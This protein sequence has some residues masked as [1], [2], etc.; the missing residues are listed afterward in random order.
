MEPATIVVVSGPPGAGKT[1]L[2]ARL[3]ERHGWTVLAK[4]T[5]KEALF[6]TLGTRDRDWSRR[7]SDASFEMVFRLA[8]QAI[9]CE[10]VI[11]LEGNFR[12]A[13]HFSRVMRL[14]ATRGAS[15]L[16]V[17]LAAS[18][19]VLEQRL[20]ERAAAASRHAGHRDAELVDELRQS[21][22]L[23]SEAP[24]RGT[25]NAFPPETGRLEFDTRLLDDAMLDRI[26][27]EV[28]AA[29]GEAGCGIFAPPMAGPTP[30]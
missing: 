25:A 5:I 24:A 17:A 26:T 18:G 22:A 29:V 14:A 30:E 21:G 27:A 10:R 8:E 20:R 4:D 1:A 19:D 16:E 11:V 3:R 12:A 15:V 2:A 9:G 13:E 23:S 28:A 7:L 6:D